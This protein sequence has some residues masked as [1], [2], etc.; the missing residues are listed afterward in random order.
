[1]DL[2]LRRAS[3]VVLSI[4]V[5]SLAGCG[6]IGEG[7]LPGSTVTAT[8]Q[9]TIAVRAD[10]A[11]VEMPESWRWPT[12]PA[13]ELT[14][15]ELIHE[16]PDEG[17]S[18]G[19]EVL[20]EDGPE[21]AANGMWD[22]NRKGAAHPDE[23]RQVVFL[24]PPAGDVPAIVDWVHEED[25]DTPSGTLADDAEVAAVLRCL[26]ESSDAGTTLDAL[27]A[28]VDELQQHR[29]DA[30]RTALSVCEAAARG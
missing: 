20:L 30:T 29:D 7:P 22:P 26:A 3:H 2:G 24:R 14:N 8:V 5:V 1:M 15:L 28:A 27:I 17:L 6:F 23:G 21:L 10:V 13:L 25:T 9:S 11:T 4:A 19:S 18:R 16:F 12:G